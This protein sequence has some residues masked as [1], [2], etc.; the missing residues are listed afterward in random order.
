MRD[1]LSYYFVVLMTLFIGFSPAVHAVTP[2]PDIGSP[3]LNDPYRVT[4]FTIDGPG[5]LKIF[6]LAG[7]IEVFP[8]DDEDKVRIELYIDRGYAFW[9]N[10]RNLDN[11]R[12]TS[13]QRGNEI[14]ASVEEKSKDTGL[15]SDQMTFS[16]K[17]YAPR[18]MSAQ[19][20]TFGGHIHVEGLSGNHMMRTSGGNI[21]VIEST[22]KVAA[23]TA[24]GTIR[25]SDLNGTIFAHTEGGGIDGDNISGEI[26]LRVKGGDINTTGVS[27]SML[28]QSD[29]G[30]INAGFED[31]GQGINMTTSAG[32][33][34][35]SI[36][37]M[38]DYNIN[39]AGSSVRL[40]STFD[41]EGARNS[42][43]VSGTIGN[44]GSPI[45][46]STEAGEIIINAD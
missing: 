11:Y 20:K 6:T 44:G 13:L 25:F 2:T 14:V 7:D 19:L 5:I 28:V 22:G 43:S 21:K 29:G 40:D 30:N 38:L 33:I 17:I 46:L 37:R 31:I 18:S 35:I 45:T 26:R 1:Q 3:E 9:S 8:S 27:G 34:N 32:T 23:F 16:Y 15:F 10:S 42:R 39:A 12:I 24:G 41:F 36:P 4:E